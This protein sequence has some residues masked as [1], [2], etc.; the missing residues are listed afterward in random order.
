M[1][2]P[3]APAEEKGASEMERFR[4]NHADGGGGVGGRF[5]LRA[6]ATDL[7]GQRRWKRLRRKLGSAVFP[8]RRAARKTQPPDFDL[9]GG[10]PIPRAWAPL[11]GANS[12]G[13]EPE[14]PSFTLGI[15]GA[16]SSPPGP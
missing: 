10:V 1:R 5:S 16:E 12:I 13:M 11:A 9:F 8:R 4:R 7:F 15:G 14:A 6:D 2:L 3:N